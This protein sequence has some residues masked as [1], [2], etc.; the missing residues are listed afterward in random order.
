MKKILDFTS[1]EVAFLKTRLSASD[2]IVAACIVADDEGEFIDDDFVEA[3]TAISAVLDS[4]ESIRIDN[5]AEARVL[6]NCIEGSDLR[7]FHHIALG[8]ARK[9]HLV[10]NRIIAHPRY[11]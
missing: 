10:F 11:S 4:S 3:C 1:D 5:E 8:L 7:D 2:K 6:I 9:L